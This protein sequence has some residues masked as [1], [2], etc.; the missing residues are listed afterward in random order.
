VVELAGVNVLVGLISL[1][2]GRARGRRTFRNGDLGR[3]GP[4][5]SQV[6]LLSR[7][8]I[9]APG[10]EG[11][12][13]AA[14]V[15]LARWHEFSMLLTADAEAEAVPIDPGPIDVLKVAHHGSDDAGLDPLLDRT[16][17]RLAVVSVGADNPYGHPT[18]QTIST[19]AEHHVPT[20]RTDED[21]DVTIDV[22]REGWAVETGD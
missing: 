9:E 5:G 13:G 8:L 14:L 1:R 3:R 11:P 12:T 4:R 10:R 18:P 15:L 22:T 16:A 21:G 2:S 17:P 7:S 20:L 19:L 6:C